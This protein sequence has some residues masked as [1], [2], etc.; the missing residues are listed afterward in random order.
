M[1]RGEDQRR[2]WHGV[3][4]EYL[5][6]G[7]SVATD[8]RA[9]ARIKRDMIRRYARPTERACDIGCANGGWLDFLSPLVATAVG[10]DRSQDMLCLAVAKMTQRGHDNAVMACCDATS[11]AFA[12]SSFGLIACYSTL[13]LV[14]EPQAMLRE[15]CR[16]MRPSA[17]L[18]IDVMGR[19]NL[20][21]GHWNR[22]HRRQG[23]FGS[24]AFGWRDL[25]ATFDR[26]GMRIV[27]TRALGVFDQWQ[28]VPGLRYLLVLRRFCPSV[29]KLADRVDEALSNLPSLRPF[30][31]RWLLAVER[32]R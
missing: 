9:L 28:F 21:F 19:H 8:R 5:D 13:S 3:S 16:V 7:Y 4:P 18:L 23:R 15:L 31:G 22:W 2:Q 24:T 25:R 26:L 12:D 1:N 27:E 6:D 32:V 11:L 29:F 20:G 30:A 14:S 17:Y 10:V